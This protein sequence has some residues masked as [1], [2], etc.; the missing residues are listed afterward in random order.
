MASVSCFVLLHVPQPQQNTASRYPSLFLKVPDTQADVQTTSTTDVTETRRLLLHRHSERNEVAKRIHTT[1]TGN[2][3]TMRST[4]RRGQH[5]GD[6]ECSLNL[7]FIVVSR[8][9]P[10]DDRIDGLF[11]ILTPRIS[12]PPTVSWVHTH[13]TSTRGCETPP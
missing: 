8:P 10:T 2:H 1:G 9:L 7:H 3:C 5:V 4:S 11:D 13:A 6:P 12:I